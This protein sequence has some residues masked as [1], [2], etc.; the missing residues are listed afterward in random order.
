MTSVIIN[1]FT[2]KRIK[3]EGYDDGIY[4]KIEKVRVRTDR[5]NVDAI[6]H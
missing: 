3:E 6:K 4:F 2:S 1:I 5:E